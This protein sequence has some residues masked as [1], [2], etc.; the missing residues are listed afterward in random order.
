[1]YITVGLT[2]AQ[3]ASFAAN[4]I[5]NILLLIIGGGGVKC[6]VPTAFIF[7]DL[8]RIDN[9]YY[10]AMVVIVNSIFQL[11]REFRASLSCNF[12]T[13]FCQA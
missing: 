12:H 3:F 10:R 7:E 2:L 6:D 1:M 4:F 11:N 9:N 13:Q 5:Y 8:Q